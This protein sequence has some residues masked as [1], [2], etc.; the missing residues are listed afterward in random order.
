MNARN[1]ISL[2][3]A[4]GLSSAASA[5]TVVCESVKNQR[6]ECDMNTRGEVRMVRQMSSAPCIEGT[7]WGLSKYTV[8]VDRGCRAEFASDPRYAPDGSAAGS[9]RSA[10]MDRGHSITAGAYGQCTLTNTARRANLYS[11]GC[12]ISETISGTSTIFTITMG[13][14]EPFKFATSDGRTWMH[15]PDRV[16]FDNRPDGG[17][18]RWAEFE[19][20]VN[21]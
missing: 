11:G 17:T 14:T 19:L 6:T 9:D 20:D 13:N 21:E 10:S 7:S 16:A 2:A 3:L 12:D 18:F 5:E 15:G 4:L 1:V 8:W